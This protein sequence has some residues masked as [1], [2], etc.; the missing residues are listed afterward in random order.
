M[1][2]KKC[3]VASSWGTL[4]CDEDGNVIDCD[5]ISQTQNDPDCYIQDIVKCDL[6]ECNDYW[7]KSFS[8]YDIL[9]LG[10]TFKDGRKTEPDLEW[11]KMIKSMQ[12]DQP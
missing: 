4:T 1:S 12:E 3:Y 8:N 11:R 2:G 7:N 10:L 5:L 9:D 6:K